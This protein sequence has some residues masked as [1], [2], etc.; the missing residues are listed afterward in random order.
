MRHLDPWRL[1]VWPIPVRSRLLRTGISTSDGPS[2]AEKEADRLR[3][4]K[5]AQQNALPAWMSNSTITGESFSATAEA[6]ALGANKDSAGRN[7]SQSKL[8][9]NTSTTQIDD[10]FEKLKAEQAAILAREEEEEEEEEYASEE[11]DDDFE[12]VMATGN[13]SGLGTPGIKN[14]VS[15]SSNGD[16]SR[17]GVNTDDRAIKRVKVEPEAK[18]DNSDED[19]DEDDDEVEFEDV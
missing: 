8:V 19:E 2:E 1:E 11:E 9:D 6:N 14:E 17:N 16:A 18:K 5:I 3:K 15:E 12:D 4:E 10:I 7:P 13:N